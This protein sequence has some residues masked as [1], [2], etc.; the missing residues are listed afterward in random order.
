MAV[1]THVVEI[2]RE[3]GKGPKKALSAKEIGAL[4]GVNHLK[5]GMTVQYVYLL[6]ADRP[7]C[8][9]PGCFDC[10]RHITSSTKYHPMCSQTTASPLR[11]TLANHLLNFKHALTR[12]TTAATVLQL[13]L[14]SCE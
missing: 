11:W 6:K 1:E 4:N 5:L 7:F 13:L 12:S 9:Q 2:L 3:K 14:A 10:L 8:P